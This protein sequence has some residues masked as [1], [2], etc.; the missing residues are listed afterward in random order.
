MRLELRPLIAF[1]L[2]EAPVNQTLDTPWRLRP[3]RSIR[4][5]ARRRSA[6]AAVFVHGHEK[7][8][9]VIPELFQSLR[10]SWNSTA[11]TNAAAISGVR[12]ISA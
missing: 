4:G 5:P 12:A 1:R 10:T 9:T 11:A 2:H 8:F 6:V 7:A 3:R